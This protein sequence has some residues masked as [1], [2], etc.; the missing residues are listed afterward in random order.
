MSWCFAR[1]SCWGVQSLWLRVMIVILCGFSLV[2]ILA[3][4]MDYVVV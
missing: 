4:R 1:S 3:Q 2:A